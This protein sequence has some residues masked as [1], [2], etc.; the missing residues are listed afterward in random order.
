MPQSVELHHQR[1]VAIT[2]QA[3]GAADIHPLI[4]AFNS[5]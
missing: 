3:S 5:A 2:R 1:D 4:A